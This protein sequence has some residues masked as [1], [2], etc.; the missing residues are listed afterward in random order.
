VVKGDSSRIDATTRTGSVTVR[1]A[2]HAH[3]IDAHSSYG[4]IVVS[5]SGGAIDAQTSTGTVTLDDSAGS[6]ASDI[7]GRSE[8][9]AVTARIGGAS[10]LHHVDLF[11][12]TGVVTLTA[13][14]DASL[15]ISAHAANGAIDAE[16]ISGNRETASGDKSFT[17]SLNGGRIPVSLRSGYG[18]VVVRAQ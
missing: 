2:A 17:G 4:N 3:A 9:G 7:T 14:R 6:F 10:A 11:A 12:S 16:G 18:T 8:Y 13:A 1:G 5:G 15:S